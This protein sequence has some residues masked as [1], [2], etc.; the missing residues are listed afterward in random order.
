MLVVVVVMVIG[1]VLAHNELLPVQ[2]P[3][4]VIYFVAVINGSDGRIQFSWFSAV[5]F[6]SLCWRMNR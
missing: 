1:I 4:A 6:R 3:S 2:V 5:F